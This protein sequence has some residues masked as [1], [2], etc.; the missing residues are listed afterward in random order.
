M[1]ILGP[2]KDKAIA[3]LSKMQ[4]NGEETSYDKLKDHNEKEHTESKP[5]EEMKMCVNKLISAVQAGNTDA[6]LENLTKIVKM[7][8]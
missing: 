1:I 5:Q 8:K 2:N 6:V 3:I 4:K 7:V